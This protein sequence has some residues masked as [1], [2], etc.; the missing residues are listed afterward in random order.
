MKKTRTLLS[1]VVALAMML[2]G[3]LAL[4][5]YSEGMIMMLDEPDNFSKTLEANCFFDEELMTAEDI[6]WTEGKA[7]QA[8]DMG[9]AYRE[10]FRFTVEPVWEA[11]GLTFTTWI[12]WRGAGIGAEGEVAP[13]D[14]YGQLILGMSGSSGHFKL[15]ASVSEENPVMNF[16]GGLYGADISAKTEDGLP[17]DEWVMVTVTL[18]GENMSLY[19]NGELAAQAEQTIIPD[20]LGMDLLRVGSSFW[21]PPTLNAEIDEAAIWARALSAEEIAELYASYE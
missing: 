15:E 1:L 18:D 21:G 9:Q 19:L 8:V 7:G 4:A 17:K 2:T 3:G 20:D 13:A 5:D 16:E 14:E 6:T 12:L 10:H 11:T